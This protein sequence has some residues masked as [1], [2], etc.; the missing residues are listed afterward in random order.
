MKRLL[1]TVIC[2]V[3]LCSLCAVPSAMADMTSG[4]YSASAKGF[5]GDVTV[6]ITV[7]GS[8]VTDVQ[9]NGDDETPAV[10]GAALETL[11]DQIKEQQSAEIDGVSG[12]TF[13]SNAARM[14]AAEVFDA[15]MGNENSTE[16]QVAADGTYKETALSFGWTGPL[17]AE[18]T[19]ADNAIT[20]IYIAEEYDTYTGEMA[21]MA[22]DNFIPR[23]L[24]EQSLNVDAIT[25]ATVTSNAIRECVRLAIEE[26]GGNPDE[27]YTPIAKS[28]ETLEIAKDNP[29]DVIVVGMGGS[30]I[31]S[32][33]RAADQ[34]ARVYGIE[35]SAM[36]G[37]QSNTIYGPMALNSE[38]LKENFTDGE[39][40]INADEVYDVWINAVQGQKEQNIRDNVYRSGE[41]L[42]YYINNFGFEFYL[43]LPV[44]HQPWEHV[45]TIYVPD[46]TGYNVIGPNKNY[47]F[48]RAVDTALDMNEDNHVEFELEA[49]ALIFDDAGDIIGVTATK[50]DGTVYNV[51]GRSVVLATGGYIGNN[52]LVSEYLGEMPQAISWT[53]NNGAGI[54]MG[55]SAGAAL[56]NM[57][58]E[59]VFH[60]MQLKN[61]IRTDV[62]SL[63]DKQI[64]AAMGTATSHLAVIPTG[65]IVDTT[66]IDTVVAGFD[67]YYSYYEIYTQEE[68][69]EIRDN[70]L[71]EAF[72]NNM[73]QF[74][75]YADLE[76]GTPVE[77][78]DE[79]LAVGAAHKDVI[80]AD[81]VAELASD[82]GCDEAVLNASLEGVDG[83]Y[84]AIWASGYSY[85]T[86]GG[87]DVNEY[88]NVLDTE[89][90]PIP[91]LF[92]V[93]TDSMGVESLEGTPFL[94]WENCGGQQQSYCIVSGYIA[95][96]TAAAY[97][98]AVNGTAEA[99]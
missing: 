86:T 94:E 64:L 88:Y 10:G 53:I 7:D 79:I 67:R 57:S 21:Y 11:A 42:D 78:I 19:I 5:G 68:I 33:T 25:G 43:V 24:E 69:D 9:V 37:G 27:W 22:F 32:F 66:N 6:T 82:I 31:F 40:Y 4:T 2:I 55:L 90:N 59:P 52:E 12:A 72:A 93:G 46:E 23:V 34:G 39:D 65:E 38:F 92:A 14:A 47:Q 81:S 56:W 95:G 97:G 91:G 1:A 80:F 87:L 36:L 35:K 51:Y 98:M 61:M 62:L 63:S 16:K 45:W 70:G 18:V 48:V 29:Y 77:N 99:A 20:E 26:A 15:A 83:P 54:K 74:M 85:G 71:S 44:S 49:T 41:L 8:S 89:G 28:T 76:T 73:L 96:E 13:T 50:S 58:S 60:N 75:N 17:T 84:V 3:I 30:G